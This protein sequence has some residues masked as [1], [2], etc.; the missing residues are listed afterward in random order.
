MRAAAL[1]PP[2]LTRLGEGLK[3]SGRPGG[4]A[5]PIEPLRANQNYNCIIYFIVYILLY[6]KIMP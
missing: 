3:A 6:K 2:G 5:R 4:K 1:P